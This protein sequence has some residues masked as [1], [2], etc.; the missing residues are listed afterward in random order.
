MEGKFKFEN[1]HIVQNAMDFGEAIGKMSMNFPKKENYNLC[2]QI[3]RASYSIPLNISEGSIFQSNP[4]QKKLLDYPIRPMAEVVTCLPKAN[5][6]KS[7]SET[8]F[9]TQYNEAFHQMNIMVAFRN[10]IK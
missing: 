6:R 7:I 3:R 10:K 1:L 2:S 5:R 8:E 4:E 9:E